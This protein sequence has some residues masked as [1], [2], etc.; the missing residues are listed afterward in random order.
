MVNSMNEIL[1]IYKK[2]ELFANEVNILFKSIKNKYDSCITCSIGCNDCCYAFF[3][4]SF[5]E[6]IYINTKF[7]S[8]YS[9]G[10]VRSYILE[11]AACIDRK[12]VKIK[13]KFFTQV[14]ESSQSEEAIHNVME[15][16]ARMRIKCP[17]LGQNG[18]CIMYEYRPITCR[19][20]GVPTAIGDKTYVCGK[21]SFKKGALYE[22]I[23]INKVQDVL[24]K[25]SLDAQL[26]LQS[27]FT[28]LH[29]IYVPISMALL[30]TYDAKYLGVS[31][32]KER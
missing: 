22:T 27:R 26:V 23:Y 31:P 4:I 10:P 9:Y 15:H 5:I 6:A 17:L 18:E 12:V 30:T 1:N 24:E 28:E 32:I 14:K 3:D 16:S 21:T 25:L 11:N 29:K 2:Y 7:N 20:Y 19:L 8:I 13:K